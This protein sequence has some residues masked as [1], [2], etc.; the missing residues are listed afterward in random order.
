MVTDEELSNVK[1]DQEITKM[2]LALLQRTCHPLPN[3]VSERK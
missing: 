1:A 3:R 2:N